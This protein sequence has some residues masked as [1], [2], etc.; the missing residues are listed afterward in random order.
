MQN[1]IKD[2]I[3]SNKPHWD[4]DQLRKVADTLTKH[5]LLGT[6]KGTLTRRFPTPIGGPIAAKKAM[7]LLRGVIKKLPYS[8]ARIYMEE[9]STPP[10]NDNEKKILGQDIRLKLADIP[11]LLAKVFLLTQV[12]KDKDGN[13]EVESRGFDAWFGMM[14][15]DA[16]NEALVDMDMDAMPGSGSEE[17]NTARRKAVT[18]KMTKDDRLFD[19]KGGPALDEIRKVSKEKQNASIKHAVISQAIKYIVANRRGEPPVIVAGD[20][21]VGQLMSDINERIALDVKTLVYFSPLLGKNKKNKSDVV[22]LLDSLTILCGASPL[23]T[24]PGVNIKL[25]RVITESG[26]LDL[27][28]IKLPS[29]TRKVD[30]V[31]II[32]DNLSVL[33]DSI[34]SLNLNVTRCSRISVIG[35][36]YKGS[37]ERLITT[38][39]LKFV[40]DKKGDVLTVGSEVYGAGDSMYYSMLG[41]AGANGER[42]IS[43]YSISERLRKSGKEKRRTTTK[44]TRIILYKTKKLAAGALKLI[45][46]HKSLKTKDEKSKSLSSISAI[47]DECKSTYKKL[48]NYK[49]KSTITLSELR[50]CL[51]IYALSIL[52]TNNN[53][54]KKKLTELRLTTNNLALYSKEAEPIIRLIVDARYILDTD[55]LRGKGDIKK[56]GPTLSD[57]TDELKKGQLDNKVFLYGRTSSSTQFW[58]YKY[59]V[60]DAEAYYKLLLLHIFVHNQGVNDTFKEFEILNAPTVEM[61]VLKTRSVILKN[62]GI[63]G[64]FGRGLINDRT[65]VL[66]I[67]SSYF[68]SNLLAGSTN[69]PQ[70]IAS[71]L[72]RG[73][74][75]VYIFTIYLNSLP[76]IPELRYLYIQNPTY[77]SFTPKKNILF[78]YSTTVES[79]EDLRKSL[80]PVK[81]KPKTL[82]SKNLG[83][84][85]AYKKLPRI[86]VT[87]KKFSTTDIVK[88]TGEPQWFTLGNVGSNPKPTKP[89]NKFKIPAPESVKRRKKGEKK[90]KKKKKKEKPEEKKPPKTKKSKEKTLRKLIKVKSLTALEKELR[91]IPLTVIKSEKTSEESNDQLETLIDSDSVSDTSLS[92][93]SNSE[94]KEK[95]IKTYYGRLTRIFE[96]NYKKTESLGNFENVKEKIEDMSGF[97]YTLKDDI[98][99]LY[100][101]LSDKKLEIVRNTTVYRLNRRR[102]DI[103]NKLTEEP[104]NLY[105]KYMLEFLISSQLTNDLLKP[106]ITID[107]FDDVSKKN[108]AKYRTPT[109]K[110]DDNTIN[111]RLII[112]EQ[113]LKYTKDTNDLRVRVYGENIT[114][115]EDIIKTLKGL[116]K[117]IDGFFRVSALQLSAQE[118][119]REN[120]KGKIDVMEVD[121]P[122]YFDDKSTSFLKTDTFANL[123]KKIPIKS[124]ATIDDFLN[125]IKTKQIISDRMTASEKTQ[126]KQVN[127]ANLDKINTYSTN[128]WVDVTKSNGKQEYEDIVNILVKLKLNTKL[129][130]IS[131]EEDVVNYKD[132][133]KYIK[134]SNRVQ[135]SLTISKKKKDSLTKQFTNNFSPDNVKNSLKVIYKSLNTLFKNSLLKLQ[136]EEKFIKFQIEETNS[137]YADL[138]KTYFND[139]SKNAKQFIGDS[140]KKSISEVLDGY[141]QGDDLKPKGNDGR[142]N[143][144]EMTQKQKD[145]RAKDINK[146]VVYYIERLENF[147]RTKKPGI[148]ATTAYVKK[149]TFK[150]NSKKPSLNNIIGYLRDKFDKN[151]FTMLKN[152]TAQASALYITLLSFD[153]S[154]IDLEKTKIEDIETVGK[155]PP[156]KRDIRSVLK[157]Y[158]DATPER[159]TPFSLIYDLQDETLDVEF[160]DDGISILPDDKIIIEDDDTITEDSEA[161]IKLT[162]E[163]QKIEGEILKLLELVR[164]K[165]KEGN[166]PLGKDQKGKLGNVYTQLQ[167]IRKNITITYADPINPKIT[168]VI[169]EFE[170]AYKKLNVADIG[171]LPRASIQKE[172]LNLAT[173]ILQGSDSK[174]NLPPS[175]KLDFPFKTLKINIKETKNLGD[176]TKKMYTQTLK[177]TQDS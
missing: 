175:L 122:K 139:F 146:F 56:G 43:V 130:S 157:E 123:Y 140:I 9:F 13:Y 8:V 24:I 120:R 79:N 154:P 69:I 100:D 145:T 99:D 27:S 152:K 151:P 129:Q 66:A 40:D 4:K 44:R 144:K 92:L 87:P 97:L 80:S 172:I 6:V 137:I 103:I 54:I 46:K 161:I 153:L 36:F 112:L 176:L 5:K 45:S 42:E 169:A 1:H 83:S 165:G 102:L 20:V 78:G 32:S 12:K 116:I 124:R 51:Q 138:T 76:R 155:K 91:N 141:L 149:L 60:E 34:D 150:R 95:L 90:K 19:L 22:V 142:S 17:N 59:N 174:I 93:E 86:M 136:K 105:N 3:K 147:Q 98:D 162:K 15:L 117:D 57:V 160:Q 135:K 143:E 10:N 109:N 106:D 41:S 133:L 39:T 114:N 21:K 71:S 127:K 110:P 177:L 159:T 35:S 89:T 38:K 74:I 26:K 49:R 70:I 68:D 132:L 33:V 18:L 11:I 58:V 173:G 113:L 94:K 107:M 75:G 14:K 23:V 16:L 134:T 125:I 167:N 53:D 170:A 72:P 52:T 47:V 48:A 126:I 115:T 118:V 84:R 77:T 2:I 31:T 164:T 88:E 67:G 7:S 156:K 108:R 61:S 65:K 121:D 101:A 96:I 50:E 166:T 131:L 111:T 148:D 25:L 63:I 119:S 163:S 104:Q 29:T 128:I 73:I 85:D 64:C 62:V 30:T 37:Y 81:L 28:G 55:G 168:K 171:F 82:K 158:K